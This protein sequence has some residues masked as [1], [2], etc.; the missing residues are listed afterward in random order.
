TGAY[1]I[2]EHGSMIVRGLRGSFSNIMGLPVERL[3]SR[4]RKLPDWHEFFSQPLR[5]ENGRR[6]RQR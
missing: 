6:I 4:W 1:G 3:Q 5:R 2:Q